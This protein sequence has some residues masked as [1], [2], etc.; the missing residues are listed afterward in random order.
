MKRTWGAFSTHVGVGRRPKMITKNWVWVKKLPKKCWLITCE[1]PL[2][3]YEYS[4]HLGTSHFFNLKRP[5]RDPITKMGVADRSRS[6]LVKVL[7]VP[8]DGHLRLVNVQKKGLWKPLKSVRRAARRS[9]L[10]GPKVF[11]KSVNPISTRGAHY[12][13]PVLCAHAKTGKSR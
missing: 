10:G 9:G 5:I 6:N 4:N 12:P 2:G 7:H 3:V 11:G 13:H 1:S 8:L